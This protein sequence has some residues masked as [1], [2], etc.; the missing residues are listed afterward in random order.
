M[1][2]NSSL[3]HSIKNLYVCKKHKMIRKIL[4]SQLLWLLILA[5]SCNNTNSIENLNLIPVQKKEGFQYINSNGKVLITPQF[6]NASVFKNG[7][8]LVRSESD[9]PKWGFIDKTGR[10]SLNPIYKNASIFSENIAFVVFENGSPTAINTKGKVLFSLSDAKIVRIF[11]NGLAAFTNRENMDNW[12]FVNT[13]GTAVISEQFYEVSNFSENKCAVKNAFGKWG[14]CNK[15]GKLIIAYQFEEAS[16]FNDNTAIVR[17]KGKAGVI[18]ENG[19]YLIEPTFTSLYADNESYLFEQNKKWGWCNK[20]G[21]T[22]IEPTFEVASKFNESEIASVK[23]GKKY[24]YINKNGQ[25]VINP[26]FDIALPFNNNL[27]LVKQNNKIGFINTSGNYVINPEFDGYS[28]DYLSYVNSGKSIFSEVET[29]VFNVKDITENIDLFSPEGI[30][31]ENN[32]LE[33]LHKHKIKTSDIDKS[34]EEIILFQDKKITENARISFLLLGQFFKQISD[35]EKIFLPD[36]KPDGFVY[37]IKLSGRA[38]G[39]L[40]VIADNLN[41]SAFELVKSGFIQTNSVSLYKNTIRNLVIT[42]NGQNLTI[43]ILK[44]DYDLSGYTSSITAFKQK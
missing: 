14:Y 38:T 11:K 40:K 23:I 10:Y 17:E 1:F 12:G 32:Y 9:L 7:L 24:G 43:Y 2:L 36:N 27:A 3:P 18:D 29:D 25:M 16:D 31:F 20:K 39:K 34:K 33:I 41:L 28:I 30:S 15:S 5:T 26:K 44:P 37:E 4:F 22:I 13:K 19:N 6:S 8:A 35:K 42:N 21:K